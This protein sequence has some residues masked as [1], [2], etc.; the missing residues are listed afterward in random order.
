MMLGDWIG[1]PAA[2]AQFPDVLSNVECPGCRAALEHTPPGLAG[3]WATPLTSAD[4]PAWDIEDFACFAGCTVEARVHAG[5]LLRD[6]TNAHRTTLELLPIA[7]DANAP[8]AGHSRHGHVLPGSGPPAVP[9]FSCDPHGLAIQVLS[10]LPLQIEQ[11]PQHLV[12][13]YEE[14]G[15]T[16]VIFLGEPPTVAD[17]APFGISRGRIEDRALIVETTKLPAGRLHPWFGGHVHTADLLAVERYVTS[18]DGLELELTL[19][20]RDPETLREPLIVTKRWRRASAP[21]LANHYCDIMSGQL[22]P[23]FAEYVDPRTIDARRRAEIND[24]R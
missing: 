22:G 15:A 6:P 7:V 1:A 14:L 13:R 21:R 23:V 17:S 4:D 18:D 11:H 3:V 5:R 9:G 8:D 10:H 2:E 20:L 12:F 19:E 16:R 24:L